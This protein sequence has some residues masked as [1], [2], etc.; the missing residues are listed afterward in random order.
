MKGYKRPNGYVVVNVRDLGGVYTNRLLHR[1]ILET[2]VGPC[3]PG[4]QCCHYNDIKTDNRLEN[5]RWDT[6][7]ANMRDAL[8]NGRGVGKPKR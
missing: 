2:F 4:M 8:R 1:L 6:P 7:E 3:P 5:L